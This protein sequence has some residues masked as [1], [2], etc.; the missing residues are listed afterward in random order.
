MCKVNR[1]S[2]LVATYLVSIGTT[3]PYWVPFGVL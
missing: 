3:R 1:L 2:L